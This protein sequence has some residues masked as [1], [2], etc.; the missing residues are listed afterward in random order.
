M[1]AQAQKKNNIYNVT[2]FTHSSVPTSE[3]FGG[4]FSYKYNSNLARTF[5]NNK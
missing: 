2:Q 1:A 3:I 5:L 4:Q